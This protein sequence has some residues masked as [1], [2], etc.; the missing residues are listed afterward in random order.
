MAGAVG[1]AVRMNGPRVQR[2]IPRSRARGPS[3]PHQVL[4]RS[5]AA[6]AQNVRDHEPGT[7]G[8]GLRHGPGLVLD[9][10]AR[11]RLHLVTDT[12]H[13]ER[14]KPRVAPETLPCPI[15]SHQSSYHSTAITETGNLGETVSPIS[16]PIRS[17][18]DE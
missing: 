13:F 12:Q 5:A 16:Q 17:Q 10:H 15:S 7:R 4:R 2:E 1:V 11:H 14:R 3:A 8:G 6:A 9:G 18:T